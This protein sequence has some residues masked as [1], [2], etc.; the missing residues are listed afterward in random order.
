MF[1]VAFS[2]QIGWSNFVFL[3]GFQ[4]IKKSLLETA[5]DFADHPPVP[6]LKLVG[7]TRS[8]GGK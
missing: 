6:L 3:S 1:G 8:S 7:R 5:E 4:M 2:M